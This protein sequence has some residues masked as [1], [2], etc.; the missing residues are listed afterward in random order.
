MKKKKVFI[1][2]TII[3]SLAILVITVSFAWYYQYAGLATLLDIVP[4]DSIKIV[5]V[6]DQGGDVEMLDLDYNEIYGDKKDSVT[7]KVT[8]YR[9]LYVSS[10]SPV[11]QLEIVH[12]TNLKGL[13]FDLYWTDGTKYTKI[14]NALKNENK[15]TGSYQNPLSSNSSLANPA[16]LNNYKD[17]DSVEEHAYPLYWLANTVGDKDYVATDNYGKVSIEVTSTKEKKYDPAKQMDRNYYKTQYY[18][19]IS[20]IETGKETDLFYILA[21]NVAVTE[22]SEGSVVTP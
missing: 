5:P 9:P 12:T 19:V 15:I 17:G 13:T 14:E 16:N 10:T 2:I 18:L 7:K 8:I 1:L 3:V 20:W 6:N 22:K 11:H 4:P 21:Q